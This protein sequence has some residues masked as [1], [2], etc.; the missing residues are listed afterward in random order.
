MSHKTLIVANWKMN[1]ESLQ[2]G[3]VLLKSIIK[4]LPRK[5]VVS[6][7]FAVPSIFLQPLK[8]QFKNLNFAVQDVSTYEGGAH[9]GEISAYQA[10]S[11]GARY[12][13]IGHSEKRKSGDT[14]DIVALKI[15]MAFSA[16]LTPILCIGENVRD[17]N[18]EYLKVVEAQIKS[19]CASV[20]KSKLGKLVIAYEPVWAISSQHNRVATHDECLEMSIFIRRILSDIYGARDAEK[21]QIIY[22]GSADDKN[23]VDFIKHGGVTGLLPG[24]ASLNAKKFTALIN[25]LS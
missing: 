15:K 8:K 13:I 23:G 25:L 1:P 19:A 12:G 16:G 3:V 21:V 10:Y 24:R 7:V 9:T 11:V 4:G 20:S 6:I 22:G 2:E 5:K 17:Q 14:D 18:H